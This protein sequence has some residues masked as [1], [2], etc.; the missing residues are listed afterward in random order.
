MTAFVRSVSVVVPVYNSS[1]VIEQLVDRV[2]GA[3]AGEDFELLLVNDG[4]SD[5][6]WTRI[7]ELART[8]QRVRGLDLMRN[9]RQHSAHLAGIRSAIG[10]ALC[11]S[12]VAWCAE[13]G[14]NRM[15]VAT[16]ARNVPA[17]RT[18]ERVGL[19]VANVGLW[20]HKWYR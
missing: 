1:G 12:A 14:A 20:F 11:E 9:Y 10:V 15:T 7:E 5:D 18:F 8:R 6:S 4:S 16:Q 3:L 17:L 13:R 19:V 2:E